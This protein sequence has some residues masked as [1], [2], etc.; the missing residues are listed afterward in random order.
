MKINIALDNEV[1]TKAKV[2]AVL[3]GISL[4][5]YFEKAIEKAAAKERKLL[6]KLR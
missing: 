4:N 1:H 5:E 2:L 6:E 3:K